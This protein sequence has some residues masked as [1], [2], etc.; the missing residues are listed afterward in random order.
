[1]FLILGLTNGQ[2]YSSPDIFLIND[3]QEAISKFNEIVGEYVNNDYE[4]DKELS[5]E[6]MKIF[7]DEDDDN[8]GAHFIELDNNK[9]HAI[10]IHTCYVAEIF[11]ESFKSNNEARRSFSEMNSH[12]VDEIDE[13][14]ADGYKFASG[15]TDDGSLFNILIL[16]KENYNT[17]YL[18]TFFEITEYIVS[19]CERERSMANNILLE[20]GRG[21]LYELAEQLTNEFELKYENTE[22]DGE[23]FDTIESFLKLKEQEAHHGK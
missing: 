9:A 4:L 22:W 5:N 12:F 19:T 15:D 8:Y 16:T 2:G 17:S 11:E 13:K 1:M 3:R 7:S 21:G 18:E 14:S 20:Q 23:F 10:S 6:Y